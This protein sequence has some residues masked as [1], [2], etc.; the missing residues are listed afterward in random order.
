MSKE[1][2]TFTV[3]VK[4]PTQYSVEDVRDYVRSAVAY[5][6]RQFHPDDEL[7]DLCDTVVV[8]RHAVKKR[9]GRKP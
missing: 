1:H 5:W 9:Q 8:K 4:R 7:F 2:V 6:G 3:T